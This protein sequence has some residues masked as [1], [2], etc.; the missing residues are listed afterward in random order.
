MYKVT[1]YDKTGKRVKHRAPT[2][3]IRQARVYRVAF[4]TVYSD[5]HYVEITDTDIDETLSKI[6]WKDTISGET[7]HGEPMSMDVAMA[8]VVRLNA[9]HTNVDHWVIQANLVKD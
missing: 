4:E 1:V 2:S 8:D 7:G 5:D 3:D 9:Q 6:Y